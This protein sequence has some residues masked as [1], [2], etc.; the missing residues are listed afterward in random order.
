LAS[1]LRSAGCLLIIAAAALAPTRGVRAA[2]LLMFRRAGCAWC[3]E[4]DRTVGRVY[5]KT[6]VGTQVQLR[7][8][9]LDREPKS[10]VDLA[11]PVRYAPTFVLISDGREIGRIEGFPGEDF[12]WGRLDSLIR[13]LPAPL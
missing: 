8:L 10:V 3:A 7:H 1:R 12:F 11:Y 9:D 2:E 6:D 5:A 13:K 4:F